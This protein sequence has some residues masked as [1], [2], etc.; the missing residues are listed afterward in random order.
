[1]ATSYLNYNLL[2]STNEAP[3][4]GITIPTNTFDASWTNT[5]TWYQGQIYMG[6][7]ERGTSAPT[8]TSQFPV[9][10]YPN[11]STVTGTPMATLVSATGVS[12]G[13]ANYLAA[14][15]ISD[16]LAPSSYTGSGISLITEVTVYA[17]LNSAATNC[18]LTMVYK[19]ESGNVVL[20]TTSGVSS[21]L[22]TTLTAYTFSANSS[23]GTITLSNNTR[24]VVELGFQSTNAGQ[25]PNVLIRTGNPASTNLATAGDTTGNLAC[26]ARSL[27][28]ITTAP[29][30]QMNCKF[31]FRDLTA[32]PIS[33]SVTPAS[34]LSTT[35]LLPVTVGVSAAA[36]AL[37]THLVFAATTVSV[38]AVNTFNIAYKFVTSVTCSVNAQLIQAFYILGT[39]RVAVEKI[40]RNIVATIGSKISGKN[41]GES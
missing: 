5:T 2:A 36:T 22:T 18:S 19:L 38:A 15:F 9:L 12:A 10:G 1:M 25:A 34:K 29:S 41:D 14:Q 40:Y 3:T 13:V 27:I 23:P 26:W 35:K 6:Y 8:N 39:Y 24:I 21:A 17:K 30:Q 4:V 16:T 31:N 7:P 28:T 20:Y 32:T 11:T 37:A 33:V